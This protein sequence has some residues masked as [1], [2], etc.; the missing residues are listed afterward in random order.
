MVNKKDNN[1]FS[2]TVAISPGE[3]IR[4]NMEFLGM[5][6]R[7]LAARLDITTKHLSN[8]IN[9][10]A[11]ITYDT[12]LKL[13]SVI[14]PS[15][16]FWMNLETNYQL[17]KARLEKQVKLDIDLAIL[18]EIPYK[19]MSEFGWVKETDVRTERVFNCRGFFG[20]AELSSIKLSYAMAF[21]THKQVREISDF[22]VLAW[23]RKA[24]LEG[25]NVEVEKFNKRK[26]KSFIPTFRE[27]TLKDPADFYPE[28]KRLCAE[29]GVALVLVPYLPRTYICGATIWR[30]NK[31]I[32]ALSVKGKKADVFWFTFF[33]ELAHLINH[34]SNEFHIS[35]NNASEEDEA[36]ELASNYL[37]SEEQY[38]NFIERYD[39]TD[40][41]QIVKYSHEIGIAPCILLGRLQHDEYIGYQ[42]YNDLKPSFKIVSC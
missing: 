15:A 28:M 3:T 35:F 24:E 37:I 26:L 6:Q 41:T 8:I 2:P 12:A 17:N 16:Q 13:E 27:L 30:N 38:R 36:D 21:R 25:L 31:A 29:C 39:Y 10:N 5:N 33:H 34:S 14:G 9:G 19:E 11:P 18:K 7:E 4:E 20:V 42:C 22:G 32:I 40:K 1:D 23:L